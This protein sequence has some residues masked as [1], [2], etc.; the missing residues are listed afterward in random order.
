MDEN[1]IRNNGSVL[2]QGEWLKRSKEIYEE[3][4]P[5]TKYGSNK[6]SRVDNLSTPRFTKET[7][8]KINQSERTIS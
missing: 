4:Y 3:L 1:I 2:E 8:N 6:Y 5:E 7:S